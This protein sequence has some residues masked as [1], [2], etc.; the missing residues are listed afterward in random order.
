MCAL[1][2]EGTV[3][4][5]WLSEADLLRI[6][7]DY[8]TMLVT[9][10]AALADRYDRDP[11]YPFV[12]T[13]LD[14]I[15]G[16]DFLPDDPIRG[17][18]TVYGWI[19]G[20][21]LEALAGH[22]WWL[23]RRGLGEDLVPR[24]EGMM[25]TVLAKL[26]EMRALN[27]G[28]LAFFMTPEGKPFRLDESGRP[29]GFVL[30][31]D[32]PYG[33]S[34]LFSA[35][36]MYAVASYLGDDEARD[37]ALD[38]CLQVDR[39]IWTGRFRNDQVS[40]DPK[41]PVT[42]K[43]GYHPHG[44]FMIQMG[45]AALLVGQGE[46]EGVEMGL[47][48]IRHELDHYINVDGRMSEVE[49][50]DLWEAVDDVGQPFRED[51]V[52]MSDPGHALECVG[53]ALKFTEA[54]KIQGDVDDTQMADI[55]ETERVMPRVLTRNFENGFMREPGGISK[56]F[57]LVSRQ[58][59]NTDLPWWNLPETMRAAAYCRHIAEDGETEKRC[60]A[61]LRDCHNVFVQHYV[62]PD[63]HLMAYQTRAENGEP[64]AVIPATAYA[65]PG[66]HTGLSVIDLLDLL[67]CE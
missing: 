60:L 40:L 16:Q 61:I 27:G 7:P 6:V 33:F 41:N 36:G 23:R 67:N 5:E 66:Y 34:D 45:T 43:L 18:G 35:K 38:Y 47:R 24:L 21:G 44:P 1:H 53:L 19:Q 42:P 63:L 64:I 10:M 50:W 48:V 65:D 57:D 30:A 14:L 52:V 55:R 25:R 20:R 22:C 51:G 11:A 26:R 13:K 4:P 2:Y 17:K 32:A 54:V 12:D 31:Q 28:H 9:V 37:E 29:E 62:R 56:A 3:L 46:K 58:Q 39:A 59:L 15:T 49:A 8:E